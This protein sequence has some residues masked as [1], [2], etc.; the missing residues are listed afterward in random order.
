[1]RRITPKN[2]AAGRFGMRQYVKSGPLSVRAIAGAYVVLLGIDM[3]QEATDG[4]LGFA[5]QRTEHRRRLAGSNSMDQSR[6]ASSE[7]RHRR[8]HSRNLCCSVRQ[9]AHR[10]NFLACVGRSDDGK[11]RTTA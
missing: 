3:D 8:R 5:I 2:D 6:S 4:L 1:M 7:R 11:G 10:C 9:D